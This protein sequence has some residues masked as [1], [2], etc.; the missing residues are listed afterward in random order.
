MVYTY[1]KV[2]EYPG[3]ITREEATAILGFDPGPATNKTTHMGYITAI[4][5]EN[6][7][8]TISLDIPHPP[9]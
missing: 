7:I 3:N 9:K 4:D 8:I 1:E 5:K 2:W 6:G